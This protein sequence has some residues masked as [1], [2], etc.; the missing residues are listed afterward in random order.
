MECAP[1][2]KG[3]LK[4]AIAAN[5]VAELIRDHLGAD[6]SYKISAIECKATGIFFDSKEDKNPLE[7]ELE[8]FKQIREKYGI[9]LCFGY[10]TMQEQIPK[11]EGSID[12]LGKTNR[13]IN[14]CL[15]ADKQNRSVYCVA[16]NHP[17]K[18]ELWRNKYSF[19]EWID[20]LIS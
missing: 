19:E 6:S 17:T 7:K 13:W 2:Y 10:F 8:T 12:F 3:K 1:R 15:P 18:P 11:K 9:N 20:N 16:N 5:L 14:T 4:G